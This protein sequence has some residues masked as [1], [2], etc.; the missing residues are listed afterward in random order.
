MCGKA[1]T[2]REKSADP[3]SG[4]RSHSGE[5]RVHVANSEF[6]QTQSNIHRLIKTKKIGAS[7]PLVESSDNFCSDFSLFR[8]L[9]NVIQQ[10]LFLGQI[11]HAVNYAVVPILRRL[12]LG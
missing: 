11:M 12:V 1:K 2:D 5:V 10:F 6:L 7:A 9:A 4:A 3:K 8:G